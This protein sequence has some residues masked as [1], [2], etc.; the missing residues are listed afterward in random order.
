MPIKMVKALIDI[1]TPNVE[2]EREV[3]LVING[4]SYRP[5]N[6][7]FLAATDKP[8]HAHGPDAKEAIENLAQ[9]LE[10]LALDLREYTLT[11]D[12]SIY[13]IHFK[14]GDAPVLLKAPEDHDSV[15][16]S[17]DRKNTPDKEAQRDAEPEDDG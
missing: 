7:G 4:H 1:P 11:G 13:G 16:R 10:D 8:V 3:T 5:G 12:V 14:D 9:K 6:H 17:S 15:S 2:G